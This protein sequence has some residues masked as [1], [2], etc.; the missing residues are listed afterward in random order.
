MQILKLLISVLIII[1]LLYSCSSSLFI[2]DKSYPS[3]EYY[4]DENNFSL[5]RLFKTQ[6]DNILKI[7]KNWIGNNLYKSYDFY[8]SNIL[9]LTKS[10]FDTTNG[11][12]YDKV[13][14]KP[15][16]I[17]RP[18]PNLPDLDN[19]IGNFLQIV[20]TVVI[21]TNGNSEYVQ[22][23]NIARDPNQ[24]IDINNDCFPK[25]TCNKIYDNDKSFIKLVILAAQE[26]KFLP[27]EYDGIKRK[28]RIN[29]PYQFKLK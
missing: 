14:Q 13:T 17:T 11:F 26:I 6:D 23:F 4:Y 22:L 15:K 7:Y 2:K 8:E 5:V 20:V 29:I 27:A 24:N 3:N 16:L 28:V 21:D 10:Y 25:W 1:I 12:E 19:M 9:N 18:E